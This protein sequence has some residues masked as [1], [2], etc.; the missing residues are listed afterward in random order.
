MFYNHSFSSKWLFIV[1]IGLFLA[2]S[3]LHLISNKNSA[4]Q[5]PDDVIQASSHLDNARSSLEFEVNYS[6]DWVAGYTT[7]SEFSTINIT[8]TDSQG[9]LKGEAYTSPDGTGDFFIDCGDWMSGWCPDIIPGDHLTVL[10]ESETE[11]INPIGGIL[12]DSLNA[13]ENKVSGM[14]DVAEFAG[15]QLDVSCEIWEE[16]GPVVDT[17][18]QADGGRFTCD[19][20][21]I[22]DLQIGDLVAIRYYQPDRNS[23]ITIAGWPWMWVNLGYDQ[24]GGNYHAGQSLEISAND[25]FDTLKATADVTSEWSGGSGAEGFITEDWS[26]LPTKPDIQ[27]FDLIHIE[28]SN[29]YTKLIEAGLI[30]TIVDAENDVV[31]GTI[32][33]PPSLTEPL[34]VECHPWGAWN[35]GIGDAPIKQ[36]WAE[37]DGSVPFSCEWNP[38]TE[39]DIQPGQEVAVMYI[40]PD[41]DRVIDVFEEP[42]PYL[43]VQMEALGELTQSGNAQYLIS[44]W[45]E[46]SA[47]AEEIVLTDEMDGLAYLEDSSGFPHT[48][49]G[50]G[51]IVWQ[52]GTLEPGQSTQF[53]FFAEVTGTESVT[54][55][56][57]VITSTESDQGYPWEKT[58]TLE[59]TINPNETYLNIGKNALTD[60][61]AADQYVIFVLDVCNEGITSSSTATLSD[62]LAPG[63]SLESWW[64]N[65]TGWTLQSSDPSQLIVSRP[66]ISAGTCVTV[67]LRAQVASSAEY[68]DMLINTAQINAANN[69][70]VGE[71]EAVWEGQVDQPHINVNIDKG[72]IS[73]QLIPGGLI[74]YNLHYEN[75]GNMPVGPFVLTET[76]PNK[77]TFM[78]AW[79][80]GNPLTPDFLNNDIAEW[81]ISGLE[82]GLGGDIEVVLAIDAYAQ[83]G[84]ELVNT[85]AINLLVEEEV[86]FDDNVSEWREYIYPPLPI[87]RIHKFHEWLKDWQLIYLVQFENIGSEAVYD[88]QVIDTMPPDT[89]WSGWQTIEFEPDRLTGWE[90]DGEVFQWNFNKLLP[91]E[92]GWV[93][94]RANL[95]DPGN[96]FQTYTNTVEIT[97][98]EGDPNPG[99]NFAE[100]VAT[101]NE[102]IWQ[103][104]VP[105]VEKGN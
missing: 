66:T 70:S 7:E 55:T 86:Q 19:F 36:S 53:D 4:A 64:T 84:T 29:G 96:P 12:V 17:Q 61:P 92:T 43:R 60:N 97:I 75:T 47:P 91:G 56:V 73:G 45:N 88:I 46:G 78:G 83:P 16:M 38:V 71:N 54:N 58:S 39:W 74:H 102:E 98:P 93:L 24:V 15:V 48:G 37:P 25:S 27:P 103:I 35:N 32:V 11:A 63:L 85:A 62:Q 87:L 90:F 21:T 94:F 20:D 5:V 100:T 40:E 10:T 105:L 79:E 72:W 76:F 104:F 30:E 82:N 89:E 6:Q 49:E 22:W 50:S 57:S 81:Q 44:L 14:L 67:Y 80:Q 28:V 2:I 26:W 52:V 99:D 3:S 23:V 77:T 13:S 69:L 9:I 95:A 33:A 1:G 59:N 65:E 8:L 42:A 18:A 41:G 51:P 34:V 101:R 68:G 31:S